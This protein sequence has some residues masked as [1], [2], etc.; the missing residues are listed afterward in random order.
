MFSQ[1]A[2]KVSRWIIKEEFGTQPKYH[3]FIDE[4]KLRI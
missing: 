3:S 4:N 2:I 1:L